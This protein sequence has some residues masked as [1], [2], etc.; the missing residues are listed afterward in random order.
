MDTHLFAV[1]EIVSLDFH[2]G[3]FIAKLN[4]FT[5]EAQMPP[6]GTTLQYRIKSEAESYRRVVAE[7]QL[8]RFDSQ[9]SAEP[10]SDVPPSGATH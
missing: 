6:V 4:P 5:V 3:R 2:D 9:A 8:S 7:H 1:G 10:A